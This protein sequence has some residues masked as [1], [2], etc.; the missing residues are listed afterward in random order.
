MQRCHICG[1]SNCFFASGL[2][3]KVAPLSQDNA[4]LHI[5]NTYI[6]VVAVV[7]LWST[8]LYVTVA[9][10]LRL[11]R[12]YEA[13]LDL[14]NKSLYTLSECK[15]LALSLICKQINNFDTISNVV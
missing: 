14:L 7:K 13:G 10:L 9:L 3:Q 6:S 8:L 4:K 1:K 2:D 15:L 12:V 5:I 11:A